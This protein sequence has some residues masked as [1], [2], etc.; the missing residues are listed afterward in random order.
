M[1]TAVACWVQL[2]DP[3]SVC[4]LPAADTFGGTCHLCCQ[5]DAHRCCIGE[6]IHPGEQLSITQEPMS[7]HTLCLQ[8]LPPLG[9]RLQPTAW[10][11]V[12]NNN[13]RQDPNKYQH[14]QE[15]CLDLC[16]EMMLR[17]AR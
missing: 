3:G 2:A 10:C 8:E 12:S 5:L 17:A 1:Q 9:L 11:C 13:F 14:V 7:A 6:K 15:A 4:R 16:T